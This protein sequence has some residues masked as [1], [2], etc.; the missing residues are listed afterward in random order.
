MTLFSYI[1]D[2]D[3]GYAPNPSNGVCTLAY[4][5]HPMRPHVQKDDYVIGLGKKELGNRVVYA[6]RVTETLEHD[7]YLLDQRFHDRREDANK[8]NSKK[9][10]AKS[11]QVLISDDFVYWGGKGRRL[12]ERLRGLIVGRNYK[13][14]K[15]EPLIR[16][17]LKWFKKQRR[18][19][20]GKPTAMLKADTAGK[21]KHGKKC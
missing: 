12:P 2:H 9:E 13:S 3:T 10:I 19:C 20:L 11:N 1:V 6:M 17:F 5:K 8:P 15:N 14:E 21:G 16:E 18:G 7:L 4:C